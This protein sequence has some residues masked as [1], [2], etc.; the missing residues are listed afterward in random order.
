MQSKSDWELAFVLLLAVNRCVIL[1]CISG[2]LSAD[3]EHVQWNPVDFTLLMI[4]GITA[5][6]S[7]PDID[8]QVEMTPVDF[9]SEIIVKMTQVCCTQCFYSLTFLVMNLS[10]LDY[11]T[12]L[13]FYTLNL[14]NK[15]LL[16]RPLAHTTVGPLQLVMT[17]YKICHT[18]EQIAHRDI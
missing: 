9:V 12:S 18:G 3:R 15:V 13:K 14:T 5:T 17:W 7:A 2:N 11:R 16:L 8:W 4:K 10:H 1:D 6:L